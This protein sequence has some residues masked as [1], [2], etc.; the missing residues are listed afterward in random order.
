MPFLIQPAGAFY[1]YIQHNT[2]EFHCTLSVVL[3]TIGE[4]GVVWDFTR[5][6]HCVKIHCSERQASR[7]MLYYAPVLCILM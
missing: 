6:C 7:E 4:R 1:S 3:M 2:T 5:K